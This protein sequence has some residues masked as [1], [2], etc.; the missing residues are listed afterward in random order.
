MPSED[1]LGRMAFDKARTAL[2]VSLRGPVY[3]F[4]ILS[5]DGWA[6]TARS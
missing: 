4:N 5:E 6:R 2:F 3:L 1:R